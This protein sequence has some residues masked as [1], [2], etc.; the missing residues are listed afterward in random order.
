MG[1]K[2]QRRFDGYKMAD[3]IEGERSDFLSCARGN[4][5]LYRDPHCEEIQ[6]RDNEGAQGKE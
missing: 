3:A 1:R 2:I 5:V 6:E 4:E